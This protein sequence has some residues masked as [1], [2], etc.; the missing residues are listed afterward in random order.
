MTEAPFTNERLETI[1]TR[2]DRLFEV[3][4]NAT[5]L[6]EANLNDSEAGAKKH[7][8]LM[9]KHIEIERRILDGKEDEARLDRLEGGGK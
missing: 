6:L 9:R 1:N 2:L 4:R 7:I 3:N 8:K 5:G